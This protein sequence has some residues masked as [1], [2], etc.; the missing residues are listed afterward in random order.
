MHVHAVCTK[1]GLIS[2]LF[3]DETGLLETEDIDGTLTSDSDDS[4]DSDDGDEVHTL[5]DAFRFDFENHYPWPSAETTTQPSRAHRG[6]LNQYV[7]DMLFFHHTQY[8]SS[9]QQTSHMLKQVRGL[10]ALLG[11]DPK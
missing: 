5:S 9:R 3:V 4:D 10:L 2:F 6:P 7:Q 8:G 11:H 1:G